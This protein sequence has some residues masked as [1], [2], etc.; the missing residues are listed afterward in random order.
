MRVLRCE[1]DQDR[2]SELQIKC[3]FYENSLMIFLFLRNKCCDSSVM[4]LIKAVYIKSHKMFS[5]VK[6]IKERVTAYQ[7]IP[8]YQQIF[9][10]IRVG[11]IS[12]VLFSTKKNM[13]GCPNKM[14]LG[15]NLN[16]MTH[17]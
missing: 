16:A 10:L 7:T 14:S 6:V 1:S 12:F 8:N 17:L 13:F 9:L 4:P 3:V 2:V 5:S 15:D 11:I